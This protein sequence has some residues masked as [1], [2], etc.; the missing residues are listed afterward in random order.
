MTDETLQKTVDIESLQPAIQELER[1]IQWVARS[2]ELAAGH[3]VVPVIQTR[4]KRR[5]CP[6]FAPNRWSTKEGDLCHEI[7]FTAEDLAR[8]VEAIVGTA[9]HE[10]AHLWAY[11]QGV[12]DVSGNQY[13]NMEFKKRAEALGLRCPYGRVTG[14]GWGYTEATEDMAQ[15]IRDE[16]Q[17]DYLALQ[18]F[19]LAF[20]DKTKSPVKMAKGRCACTTVRCATALQTLCLACGE[21]FQKQG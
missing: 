11:S 3:R 4:G 20:Q 10:V 7:T 12:P 5:A 15:R 19:R 18:L 1:A 6:W 14:R 9:A 16:L 2:T 13:H 21:Q 8:D 17:P